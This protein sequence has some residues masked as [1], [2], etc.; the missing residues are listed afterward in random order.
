M[1]EEDVHELGLTL[2]DMGTWQPENK[3]P[4]TRKTRQVKDE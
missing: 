2:E 3:P 4:N 1:L